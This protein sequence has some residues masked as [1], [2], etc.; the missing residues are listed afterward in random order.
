ML[1][2]ERDVSVNVH[3]NQ[4]TMV[5]QRMLKEREEQVRVEFA[6]ILETKLAGTH[7]HTH[8]E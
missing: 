6:K 7:T 3:F 4:V 1:S 2:E 5:C 8:N